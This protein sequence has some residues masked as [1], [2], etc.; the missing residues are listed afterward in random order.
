V[1][2]VAEDWDEETVA[3]NSAPLAA[4]NISSAW[5]DPLS[6]FPGYPGVAREWDVSGAVAKAYVAGEPL[7]LAFYSGDSAYH[8]GKY[9]VSSDAGEWNA[10]GRPTLKVSL[11]DP[12]AQIR[13]SVYP[14]TPAA[15]QSVTYTVSLLGSGQ[16]LTLTDK[17]PPQVSAPGPVWVTPGVQK[18]EYDARLHRLIWRD[19]PAIGQPVTITFPV[20]V[21][22]SG[23]LAIFNT[24]RLADAQGR[25]SVD[26]AGFVVDGRHVW[27]PIVLGY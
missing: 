11:G 15:S 8:S 20:T 9:F 25:V 16:A 21:Q 7:R 19:T 18:P 17:L 27:L 24:A 6:S 23:P 13:K 3:W 5:V 4:E 2:S 10:E 12:Q 14:I 26:T 22:V 1:L